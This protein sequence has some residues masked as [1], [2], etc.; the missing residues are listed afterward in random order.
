MQQRLCY[1]NSGNKSLFEYK[2]II[3]TIVTFSIFFEF[4]FIIKSIQS[5]HQSVNNVYIVKANEYA[6]KR[7][8]LTC[9]LQVIACAN[10]NR[11]RAYH[12][13]KKTEINYIQNMLQNKYKN[14]QIQQDN[15]NCMQ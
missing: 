2:P 14:K 15:N 10:L 7:Q 1:C 6:K 13:L 11:F 5:L 8:M 4:S 3:K 9:H 12:L